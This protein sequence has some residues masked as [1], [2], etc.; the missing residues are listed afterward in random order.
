[1]KMKISHEILVLLNECTVF[2]FILKGNKITDDTEEMKK[3]KKLKILKLMNQ[4]LVIYMC[5]CVLVIV[6][7]QFDNKR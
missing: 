6:T 2:V 5:A 1:M 7:Y 4:L 3:K